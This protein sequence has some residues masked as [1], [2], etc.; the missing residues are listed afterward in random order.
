MLRT[1]AALTT[2]AIGLSACADSS[3]TAPDPTG[4]TGG[5]GGPD[6][7]GSAPSFRV[8]QAWPGLVGVGVIPDN[9]FQA[10]WLN[11]RGEAAGRRRVDGEYRHSVWSNG[12]FRDLRYPAGW[13]NDVHLIGINDAGTVA[14]AARNA[15]AT[16]RIAVVRWD[17]AG[18]PT[19]IWEREND[20]GTGPHWLNDA[21][22]ISGYDGF[23]AILWRG[24]GGHQRFGEPAAHPVW[25]ALSNEGA[26]TVNREYYW[27]GRSL[28]AYP[29]GVV[30]DIDRRDI[31]RHNVAI[32]WHQPQD[33]VHGQALYD[34]DTGTLTRIEGVR[35]VSSIN[36]HG[37]MLGARR[38]GGLDLYIYYFDGA[39][40]HDINDLVDPGEPIIS[41]ARLTN[42]GMMIARTETRTM[43]LERVD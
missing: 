13:A 19:V 24:A 27:D 23:K 30:A 32:V 16:A 2:L 14:G 21:G 31:N 9:G 4:G 17:A 40:W 28:R 38:E 15:D 7:T 22:D 11:D 5:T 26:M 1:L 6:G 12:T 35:Y 36:D 33:S 8:V 29:S 18:A 34:L 41:I 3:A 42:T 20:G 37:E 43:I 10:T 25:T 39:G